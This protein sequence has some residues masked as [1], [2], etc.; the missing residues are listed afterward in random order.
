M[1]FRLYLFKTRI[2]CHTQWIGRH[3]FCQGC[4]TAN[5]GFGIDTFSHSREL[6]L[7]SMKRLIIKSVDRLI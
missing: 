7:A 6:N 3:D 4:L 2:S 5:N 1:T